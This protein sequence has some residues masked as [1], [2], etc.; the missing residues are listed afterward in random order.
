MN[1]HFMVHLEHRTAQLRS[2]RAA[3]TIPSTGAIDRHTIALPAGSIGM[4]STHLGRIALPNIG[5]MR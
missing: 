4:A 3:T 1:V 2:E 5:G